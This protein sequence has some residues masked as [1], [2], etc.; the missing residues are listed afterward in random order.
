[1]SKILWVIVAI[2]VVVVFRQWLG[3]GIISSGDLGF[4]NPV[5]LKE[6]FLSPP[7]SWETFR[8]FGLGGNALLFQGS[9]YYN[10]FLGILEQFF[11]F[12][13]VERILWLF[14]LISLSFIGA[15]F[16]RRSVKIFSSKFLPFSF[17]ILFFNTYFLTIV[18]GG[19]ITV[20]LT[21]ALFPLAVSLFF[22]CIKKSPPKIADKIWFFLI[23]ALMFAVDFRVA[24]IFFLFLGIYF[25]YH[26]LF[27]FSTDVKKYLKITILALIFLFCLNLFWLLPLFLF[28]SSFPLG[29]YAGKGWVEFLS[30]T[31]FSKSFSLLHPN[32]P[33]NIFGKTYFM[34]PEFLLIPI[35][36]FASLLLIKNSKFK[37]QITFFAF[38]ALIGSFLAKGS[39]PPFGGVYLW[40]F[41]HFPGM[42]IF[43]DSTK[44]YVLVALSYSILIPFTLEQV[45][46]KF[47]KRFGACLPRIVPKALV[48]GCLVLGAF[49]IY[50]L[51]LIRPAWLGQLGGTFRAKEVPT[52]Y[53][54]LREFISNQDDFFRTF[55]VP[56]R[57]R[58]GLYSNNHPAVSAQGF[59]TDSVCQEPLCSLGMEMPE[60]WG[61]NCP[62]NDRCY[63]RELSYFLNPKTV[64]ILS[65]MAVKYV[66]VPFDSEEEI[67]IAER[68]YN[69]QQREEIEQ[70]LDTIPWLKKIEVT[71]KISVYETPKYEGHFFAVGQEI[72]ELQWQMI[73]PT[74]YLVSV[75]IDQPPATLV[76]SETYDELWQA[77]IEEKIISSK[78]FGNLNSFP[79]NQVGEFKIK[80]EFKPQ[81]YVYLGGFVSLITLLLMGGYLVIK[82][83]RPKVKMG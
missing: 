2:L 59:V 83:T 80:V 25:L 38:L 19:Q 81:K 29:E 57:Q 46:K 37:T 9:F 5:N 65:Q 60:K 77:K 52:E 74:K 14:P 24:Y 6:Y 76:F 67:F 13:I 36:A 72:P 71:D 16:L 39:N 66:V 70:F 54:G 58:F 63:V 4:F 56:T 10:F 49:L 8:G 41:N 61:K 40:L 55:W 78:K 68:E 27:G 11:N 51:F 7:L 44:F 69:P 64:E 62:I 23:L 42:N 50:W 18:S 48:W 53:I 75:K 1:M 79:I 30:F 15:F 22:N 45:S 17:L 32:W 33:E 34:R 47:S 31:D 3:T 20:A 28:P 43:R 35:V 21:Y 82:T 26:L 12:N 73:N